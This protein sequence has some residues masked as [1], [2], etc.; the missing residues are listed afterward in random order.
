MMEKIPWDKPIPGESA[1][2]YEAFSIYRDMGVGRSLQSAWQNS[3]NEES[4]KGEQKRSKTVPGYWK[5]W[6][7]KYKWRSRCKAYDDHQAEIKRKIKEE[8]GNGQ[9]RLEI[10]E[11]LQLRREKIK[12]LRKEQW[13]MG[14]KLQELAK[15]GIKAL[16]ESPDKMSGADIVKTLQLGIE[17]KKESLG[18]TKMPALEAITTLADEG[19]LPP[20]IIEFFEE[21]INEPIALT[22]E[23]ISELYIERLK[24]E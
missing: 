10:R 14:C 4:K 20:E 3:K 15:A 8:E 24:N 6:S 11:D 18:V 21:V 17:L 7:T 22:S 1:K 13:E 9:Y 12:A 5:Q 16:G 19:L 2:A 23:K